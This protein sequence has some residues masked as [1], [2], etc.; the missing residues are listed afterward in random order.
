MPIVRSRHT[1]DDHFT[2]IPN[3][4]LRDS[5]VSFKARG[6]LALIMS[7]RS[8]WNISIQSLADNNQE[9]K[10]SIRSAIRELEDAGYLTRSQVNENGR[11][12]ESLW[13]TSDPSDKPTTENPTTENPTPK[14]NILKEEQR[15]RSNPQDELEGQ[16][17]EFWQIYPRKVEKL[18]A[19][20]AFAKA[21]AE[22]GIDAVLA[23]A[24]R[25]ATDPNLPPKQYV[26]HPASWLNSGGWE[27]EPYPERELS[28]EEKQARERALS[29][30]KRQAAL[31]ENARMRAEAEEAKANAVP[32]PKCKH[33][34][35]LVLCVPCLKNVGSPQ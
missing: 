7:H 27:D 35:N 2:Q 5:R 20:K 30:E 21:V 24:R 26:K 29:E 3:A 19:R 10:D 31:A 12:G 11:F 16:F 6:L 18:A 23:G 25:L 28:L 13:I 1:F 32:A 14:K 22:V 15:I 33:G 34:K 8:G 17:K 4:W 9:G